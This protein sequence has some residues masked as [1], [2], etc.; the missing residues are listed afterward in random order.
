MSQNKVL[1]LIEHREGNVL[2]YNWGNLGLGNILSEK[3]GTETTA[4]ILSHDPDSLIEKV[5]TKKIAEVL[6]VKSEKCEKYSPDAYT[7]VLEKLVAE[8]DV[9]AI[10]AGHTSIGW[11]VLPKL[12][13]RLNLGLVSEVSGVEFEGDKPTFSR[14]IYNGKLKE[15]V[16]VESSPY[17]LTAERG[18]FPDVEEGGSAA[19]NE[20]T[21]S[22]DDVVVR[23]QVT[24][25]VK[26]EKGG[27]DLTKSSIIVSGGRG[28]AKKENFQVVK[29]LAEALG[30]DY[31][32]SRPVVDNE[33]VERDRQVGSSGKTVTPKLYVACGISGAIQH[34]SGMKKSDTI[35][36]INK[37][38]D[39]PIF[40]VATYGIV[41]DLFE[42]VPAIIEEAKKNL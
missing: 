21:L 14:A 25:L 39:A 6:I 18:G 10:V 41:A 36:A 29:D 7:A 12:A 23:T 27:V 9:K 8:G 5:K 34:L 40:G 24:G 30:G 35:V 32:A 13:A 42:V 38:A 15:K 11:D 37:D 26:A 2:D 20:S 19:I 33:W 28:L 22:L 17:L 1:V 31:A 3:L 16:S 4:L